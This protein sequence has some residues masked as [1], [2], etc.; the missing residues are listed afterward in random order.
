MW[1]TRPFFKT[2]ET[3][4]SLHNHLLSQDLHLAGDLGFEPRLTDPESV[5][6][7][8]HQSPRDSIVFDRVNQIVR[9]S[10]LRCKPG[11]KGELA[12]GFGF[13]AGKRSPI[14]LF[15]VLLFPMKENQSLSLL[16]GVIPSN[17]AGQ[18][19]PTGACLSSRSLPP[20]V[21]LPGES[22][23]PG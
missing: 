21:G 11:R 17:Q 13:G 9:I 7:P 18:G 10:G 4:G 22:L 3:R 1:S 6:L 16:L 19:W 8:L 14:S 5:V 23:S 15:P 2:Q 12:L 20:G